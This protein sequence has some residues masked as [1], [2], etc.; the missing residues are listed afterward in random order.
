MA[1]IITGIIGIILMQFDVV[2][3][4]TY[5]LGPNAV[6]YDDAN[7]YCQ[8][9]NLELAVIET[10]D[11]WNDA[12]AACGGI[13]CWIGLIDNN[14]TEGIFEWLDGTPISSNYGFNA[15]G[16]A[17]RG[18]QP[19]YPGEPNE[20]LGWP[21][22]CTEM[23][24]N[25]QYNDIPCKGFPHRPLCYLGSDQCSATANYDVQFLI[26]ESGSVTLDGYEMTIDLVQSLIQNDISSQARISVFEFGT[27]T[28]EIYR[29]SEQQLPRGLMIGE[30]EAADY[31][32]G[33][34]YTYDALNKGITE[35]QQAIADGDINAGDDKL[36]FLITDGKPCCSS[37]GTNTDPCPLKDDLDNLGVTVIVVAVGTFD[38]GP[39]Q[40]LV[41]NAQDRIITI[42]D[43]DQDQFDAV[44]AT[45]AEITC[46]ENLV[47]PPEP[48]TCAE[49][50]RY[51][52]EVVGTQL[53]TIRTV[54]DRTEAIGVLNAAGESEGWIGLYSDD[55]ETKWQFR[56]GD[57]C[58]ADSAYKCVDFW[59]TAPGGDALRPRCIGPSEGGFQCAVFYNPDPDNGKP[60]DCV[61]NDAPTDIA[62]PFLCDS[63]SVI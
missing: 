19:W 20:Y 47:V 45:I 42:A 7:T 16:T 61:D 9:E 49:A 35:F 25:G 37:S 8:G 38:Q 36:L 30:I 48:L 17:T 41:R 33:V 52:K 18:V 32:G 31:D 24:T 22:D 29:F 21:E 23:Y 46:P 56:S 34:T 14:P 3:G 51:C 1:G 63:P 55:V 43:L 28:Q 13:E 60:D 40:C 4:K 57:E 50:Q 6:D 27:V 54:D 59:C 15:D 62:M 10:E 44:E 5:V 12:K 58:P 26:D 39:I 2:T 11:D 53:A